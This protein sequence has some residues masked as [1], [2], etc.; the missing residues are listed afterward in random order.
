MNL[1]KRDVMSIRKWI[2]T[3]MVVAVCLVM[4]GGGSP[5]RA[6]QNTTTRAEQVDR[7]MEE[8]RFQFLPDPLQ[9]EEGMAATVQG[10]F[11][12]TP[13]FPLWLLMDMGGALVVDQD[14]F[15]V[16]SLEKD[17]EGVWMMNLSCMD[18]VNG[19]FML[20]LAV[21]SKN[22]EAALKISTAGEGDIAMYQ[23]R[24]GPYKGPDRPEFKN[25]KQAEEAMRTAAMIDTLVPAMR[26]RVKLNSEL[27]GPKSEVNVLPNLV[28]LWDPRQFRMGD[29]EVVCCEKQNGV[30]YV[31]LQLVEGTEVSEP[32]YLDLAIDSWTGKVNYRRSLADRL[33]INWRAISDGEV[34]GQPEAN[35]W[36][37]KGKK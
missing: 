16:N 1:K 4:V 17:P 37:D 13:G 3:M 14:H 8:G 25:E 2:G 34:V 10:Y 6:Q 27:Y 26:F 12:K 28:R 29:Y 31:R 9:A 11:N 32:M 35:I 18:S 24:V 19:F 5:V 36:S 21:D 33:R 20:D 15:A 22:G 23:G 30:W 7:W